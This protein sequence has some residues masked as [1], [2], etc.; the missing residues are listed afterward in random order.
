MKTRDVPSI[1]R[2]SSRITFFHFLAVNANGHDPAETILVRIPPTSHFT[3]RY[4]PLGFADSLNQLLQREFQG[5][6][7]RGFCGKA[8]P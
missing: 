5:C 8:I 4:P 1:V 2:T 7:G 6:G 3:S